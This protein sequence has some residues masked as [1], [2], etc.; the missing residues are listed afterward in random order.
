M[1]KSPKSPTRRGTGGLVTRLRNNV[2]HKPNQYT[3]LGYEKLSDRSARNLV[4]GERIS[5]NK[6]RGLVA[7]RNLSSPAIRSFEHALAVH[8]GDVRYARDLSGISNRQFEAYRKSTPRSINPFKKE[9]GRWV[10]GKPKT[11]FHAFINKQGTPEYDVGFAGEQLLDM[12]KYR[13]AVDN[14]NQKD[15]DAFESKYPVGIMDRY[16]AVHHPET[17]L[18][19]INAVLR[20]MA[21]E[22]RELFASKVHYHTT[23]HAY[24]A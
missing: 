12:Q 17:S 20:R 1:A 16:G 5:Y 24:A 23:D 13:I 19:K 2:S 7:S 22:E 9:H 8:G 14:R 18:R 3:A 6:F 11:A 10:A 15:L 21:P 4:T